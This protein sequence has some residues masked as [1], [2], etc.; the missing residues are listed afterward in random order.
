MF[1]AYSSNLSII[2][3][4]ERYNL[5]ARTVANEGDCRKLMEV[6]ESEDFS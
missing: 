1:P 6:N 2:V 3:A 5:K 4:I